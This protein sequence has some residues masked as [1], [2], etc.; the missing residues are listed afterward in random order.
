MS[1]VEYRG[2][3]V[4]NPCQ[5]LSSSL[6]PIY[7]GDGKTL[8]YQLHRM[9]VRGVL[10]PEAISYAQPVLPGQP[11]VRRA[12][13]P[14]LTERAIRLI[15]QNPRGT[16]VYS[17]A[18]TEVLRSPPPTNPNF[19]AAAAYPCDATGGPVV[20]VHDIYPNHGQKSFVVDFSIETTLNDCGRVDRR[21]RP[22]LSHVF[23]E[24][25]TID[26]DFFCVRHIKGR[27]TFD[28]GILRSL[29]PPATADDYRRML[30]QPLPQEFHRQHVEVR[31]NSSGSVIEYQVLDREMALSIVPQG[32]T[33]IE[34]FETNGCHTPGPEEIAAYAL[35]AAAGAAALRRSGRLAIVAG[36]GAAI[37]RGGLLPVSTS[38][39]V[40]RVW[41]HK[42]TTRSFL[43]SV[44]LRII[45]YAWR[46]QG[47]AGAVA[48]LDQNVTYDRVGKFVQAEATHRFGVVSNVLA[49]GGF[50]N[51][52][53][54]FWT[55]PLHPT[56]DRTEGPG[57][58]GVT[59]R[60]LTDRLISAPGV[61]LGR[62]LPPNDG[63][64]RGTH[65]AGLVATA[66]QAPCSDTPAP[67]EPSNGRNLDP[68]RIV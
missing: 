28:L 12:Q 51:R 56:H 21:T 40:A 29:V 58:G 3:V 62:D 38:T 32:V 19:P 39:I 52:W 43:E 4:E 10:N 44:A 65:I 30:L 57:P 14:A 37:L 42:N 17:V 13:L 41:G 36:V 7:D 60:I 47:F 63:G 45:D 35:G 66:L 23:E 34:C 9:R 59:D 27:A 50:V 18:G 5:V 24:S 49:G 31:Q 68:N 16:F 2:L 20:T 6:T 1:R 25:H 67:P 46:G 26:Q 64:A 11:V 33:R 22:L 15:L 55:L 8:L 48:T 54:S 53:R 61:R